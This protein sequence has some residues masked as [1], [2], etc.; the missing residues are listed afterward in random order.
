MHAAALLLLLFL[1]YQLVV[2]VNLANRW[3]MMRSSI[4]ICIDYRHT[5]AL[6]KT[7]ISNGRSIWDAIWYVADYWLS[8]VWPEVWLIHQENDSHEHRSRWLLTKK[9]NITFHQWGGPMAAPQMYYWVVDWCKQSDAIAMATMSFRKQRRI[10]PHRNVSKW[11]EVNTG[12]W[13]CL[14]R[15][16]QSLDSHGSVPWSASMLP[17]K[18]Q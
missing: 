14:M 10:T 2:H 11:D 5:P 4:S 8:C 7:S 12:L 6:G 1:K 3:N 9:Y 17:K 18:D 13:R 16:Q 15:A